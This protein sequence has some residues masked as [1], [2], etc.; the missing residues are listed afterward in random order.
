MERNIYRIGKELFITSDEEVKEG[1]WCLDLMTKETFKMGEHANVAQRFGKDVIKKIILTTDPDLISDGVQ[2]IDNEFLEWFVK[3]PTC[4]FVEVILQ[5]QYHS[6]KEFYID[7][8]YVDCSK[9][10]YQ[11]IK[12][13]IPTCPL[14]I[15]YKI[16]IPQEEPK[17]GYIASETKL[18]GVLFTLKDGSKQFV[19]KKEP[20]PKQKTLKD[21]TDK[22]FDLAN[23]FAVLGYGD[24]AVLLHTIHNKFSK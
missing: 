13:E 3:N 24:E 22:L 17:I 21:L 14:R 20:K 11:S 9:E 7:A 6:S 4:D 15:L 1:C 10:Q 8:D 16:I 23:E 19:A 18:L 12:K 2:A 5:H